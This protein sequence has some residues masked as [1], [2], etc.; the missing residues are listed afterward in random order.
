[1]EPT[2]FRHSGVSKG[3]DKQMSYVRRNSTKVA[4][5]IIGVVVI[6]AVAIW[7]FYLFVTFKDGNGIPDIQGGTNHLWWAITMAVFAC[8][9]GFCVFSAFVR[10]DVKDEL[11]ITS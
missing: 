8:I 9:A 1:V 6:A 5:S 7:E 4:A 11:H 10:H 2:F 3:K